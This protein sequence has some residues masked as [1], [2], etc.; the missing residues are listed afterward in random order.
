MNFIW[1]C[2]EIKY[3]SAFGV[4][5]ILKLLTIEVALD[6]FV[7]YYQISKYFEKVSIILKVTNFIKKKL[8]YRGY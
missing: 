3:R 1:F 8:I 5:N 6:Y 4:N 7:Y 2:S